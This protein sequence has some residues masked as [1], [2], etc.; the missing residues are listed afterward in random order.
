MNG[1]VHFKLDG[2]EFS[3]CK[4]EAGEGRDP[5][6]IDMTNDAGEVTCRRCRTTTVFKAA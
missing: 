3:A 4:I 5:N 6:R 2:A 1:R